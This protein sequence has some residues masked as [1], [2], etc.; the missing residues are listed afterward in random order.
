MLKCRVTILISL[1]C[2]PL[3]A[4]DITTVSG[5]VTDQQTHHPLPYVSVTAG[6][7]GTVTNEQG[8][9]TLK[10]S[11][12]KDEVR[13]DSLTFSLIGYKNQRAAI[14]SS[15]HI[16][17]QPAVVTL[18]EVVV[19]YHS[20]ED[21][22]RAAI[23][24][25]PSN[26]SLQPVSYKG[27]YREVMQKR[28]QYI[29]ICEAIV[30]M[31]KTSYDRPTLFDAVA[32]RRGRRMMNIKSADT[33]AV[34]LKGGPQLPLVADVVKNEELLFYADDMPCYRYD[35]DGEEQLDQRPHY[36]VRMTPEGK[37]P[38]ALFN[39]VLYIDQQTLAISRADLH[40]DMS[41]RAVAT[42]TMLVHRPAGLHFTPSELSFHI[43][44]RTEGSVTHLNYVRNVMRFKC[45][46]HRRLFASNFTVTSEFVVTD[47]QPKAT[48][49]RG[50]DSF[51]SRD[52]L[53]DNVEFFDAPDF[54]GAD[55]IILPTEPLNRAIER[56]RR[57][58]KAQQ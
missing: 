21:I 4:Q 12:K 9:F 36:V 6:S 44:Y 19:R 42:S 32:I 38:Y 37:R 58:V 34:K 46:W 35:Y 17:L 22:V 10:I 28:R 3:I 49:I 15:I 54:W 56:L 43:Y 5:I 11:K 26:Y 31:Y 33:L 51:H 47:I 30:E 48:P 39:A 52:N 55:N 8:Q 45:D 50:R 7:V 57:T 25:F 16:Q 41:N 2:A 29:S 13:E 18:S 27:F 14:S 24:K 40:L 20:A 53:Y 23:S 1:F